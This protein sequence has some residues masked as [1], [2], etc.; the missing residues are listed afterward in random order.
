MTEYL[1]PGIDISTAVIWLSVRVPVLSELIADVDPRVSTERRRFM[2]APALASDCVPI[3]RIV[4]TTAGRPV[5]IAET[6]KAMA[7]TNRVWNVSPRESPRAIDA[8]SATP[9]MTRIWLVSLLSCL[10]SGVASSFSACRRPEMWPTSVAIPVAVTSTDPEPRVTFVFMYAMSTRSPSGVSAFSI[11]STPFDAGTLS[12]VRADSSISSVAARMI[13]PSAGTTSPASTLRMSP[14]T[15]WSAGISTTCPSRITLAFTSIIEA[16]AATAFAALP[17]WFR[18]MK[19]LTSV[20]MI[21][22]RPVWAW[23]IGKQTMP[24]TSRTICIGSAYWRR[25]ARQRG[26][27]FPSANLFAPK[28]WSLLAASA[29]VRPAS[30]VTPCAVSASSTVSVCH[31]GPEAEPVAGAGD[32]TVMDPSRC[33]ATTPPANSSVSAGARDARSESIGRGGPA[34][35]PADPGRG[36]RGPSPP[37]R[38]IA[39]A[40]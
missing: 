20:R 40:G 8:A 12:P 33:S 34:T 32:W 6:A 35:A 36:D 22:R 25:K 2:I 9:A 24:A 16:R 10:V 29:V 39:R 4:V 37:R 31:A 38:R 15:I 11:G 14:G 21:R 28:A 13:R 17:S 5:G 23:P 18:P 3:E 1:R 26:S 27:F 19:A 30:A 7:V